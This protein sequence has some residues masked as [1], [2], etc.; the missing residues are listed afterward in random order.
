MYNKFHKKKNKKFKITPFPQLNTL[1]F[2]L[3]QSQ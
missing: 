1:N 2:M 3:N